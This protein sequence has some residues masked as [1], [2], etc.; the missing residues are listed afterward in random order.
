MRPR[1]QGL[2]FPGVDLA[3]DLDVRNPYP[4][5]IRTPRFRYGLEVAGTPLLK[6]AS[7]ATIDLASS[8]TTTVTLPVRV[9]NLNLF[10]IYRDA[11]STGETPY[12]LTA[13]LV[14]RAM[15]HDIELPFAHDGTFPILKVPTFTVTRIR[16]VGISI[17][18]AAVTVEAEASGTLDARGKGAITLTGELSAA[19]A[20]IQLLLGGKIGEARILPSGSISTPYGA[21]RLP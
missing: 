5:A 18:R 20:V 14:L 4:V 9:D 8:T 17:S 15:G 1:I 3:F 21:V 13:S 12:R 6:N 2:D 16:P 7:A 19:N 10:K 11:S